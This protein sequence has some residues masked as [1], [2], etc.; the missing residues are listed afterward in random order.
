MRLRIALNPIH[1]TPVTGFGE[2]GE[3]PIFSA[4]YKDAENV[5]AAANTGWHLKKT[6]DPYLFI[7]WCDEARPYFEYR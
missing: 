7:E 2:V 1:G 4:L 5:L 6:W 3:H